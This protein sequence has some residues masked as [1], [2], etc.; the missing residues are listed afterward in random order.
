MAVE[1]HVS[2]ILV[3]LIRFAFTGSQD[4][5]VVNMPHDVELAEQEVASASQSLQHS[6]RRSL[7]LL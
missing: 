2:V 6:A 4:A 7:F 1:L 5:S 3:L